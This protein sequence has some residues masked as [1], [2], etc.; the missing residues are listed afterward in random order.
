MRT[1]AGNGAKVLSRTETEI[2][3]KLDFPETT[4]DMHVSRQTPFSH[5]EHETRV[6]SDARS[7]NRK[8]KR[9]AGSRVVIFDSPVCSIMRVV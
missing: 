2:T 4:G 1:P 8:E 3:I 9:G 5:G 7:Q 6:L